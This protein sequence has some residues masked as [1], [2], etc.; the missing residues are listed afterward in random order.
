MLARVFGQGR[1]LADAEESL[2]QSV[3]ILEPLFAAQPDEI[4]LQVSLVHAQ[5]DFGR[6]QLRMDKLGEAESA[7]SRTTFSPVV[8]ML[9][10]R[11]VGTPRWCIASLHK[12]SRMDDRSTAKPSAMRA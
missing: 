4:D 1:R 6:L 2:R 11:V 9:R 12:N 5:H 10:A 7:M 8:T 3:A